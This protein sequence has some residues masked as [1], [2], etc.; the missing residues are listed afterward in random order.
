MDRLRASVYLL[1]L[2]VSIV[3]EQSTPGD[4]IVLACRSSN[5]QMGVSVG[6]LRLAEDPRFAVLSALAA[7]MAWQLVEQ[8][9]GESR[10]ELM[11][12]AD[13]RGPLALDGVSSA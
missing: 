12:D 4:T 2:L 10:V 7:R 6:S 1:L 5:G 8:P 3:L 9:S 13:L 11:F